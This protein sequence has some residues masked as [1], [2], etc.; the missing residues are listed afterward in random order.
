MR[1]SFVIPAFNEEAVLGACLTSVQKEIAASGLEAEVIVVNNAS[2]DRTKEIAGG[3]TGVQVVDEPRKGLTFARQ[4]GFEASTGELIANVDADTIVPT[5]WLTTVQKEFSKNS[6]LV[7]LSG[8]YRYYDLSRFEN[9]LVRFFYGLAYILHILDQY[10]L[11]IGAMIQ[12]GN[13]VLRRDALERVGGFDTRIA[14]YGEDTDI[15][16]RMTPLGRVKWTWKLP[17]YSSGRR[18]R[19]QG[20]VRTSWRYTLNHLTII[21]LK[22]PATL[23]YTDI[24][25]TKPPTAS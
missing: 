10:V 8:P 1:I 13:F 12:G 21:F 15:A 4:A 16:C 11:R 18:L 17:M 20:L 6:K 22:R 23:E 24:R 2:T 7:A 25:E 5:G 19:T 14:F 3:F 9:I